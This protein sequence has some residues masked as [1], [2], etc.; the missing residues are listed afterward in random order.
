MNAKNI[1]K[2]ECYEKVLDLCHKRI[3]AAAEYR[4]MRCLIEVPEFV[5]GFPLY[6]IGDCMKF[7]ISSLRENGFLVRY[8]FPK[9]LY[10]SWDYDEH[11][12]E[13]RRGGEQPGKT[14]TETRALQ[15]MKRQRAGCGMIMPPINN[16]KARTTPSQAAATSSSLLTSSLVCPK[17][18]IVQ[19]KATGKLALNIY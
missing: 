15:R 10:I 1:K 6:N 8:H 19:R 2:N 11:D 7:V 5:V 4:Q 13:A 14:Q 9:I 3:K 12:E 16:N 17:K 18:T